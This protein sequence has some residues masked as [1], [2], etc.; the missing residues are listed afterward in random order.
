MAD[1]GTEELAHLLDLFPN[2][3]DTDH[4]SITA[5]FSILKASLRYERGS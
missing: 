5:E 3:F 2:I 1:Y 4:E